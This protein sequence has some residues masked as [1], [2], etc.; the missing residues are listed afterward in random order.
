MWHKE[1]YIIFDA[2]NVVVVHSINVFHLFTNIKNIIDILFIIIVI[3]ILLMKK[4]H[5]KVPTETIV[6][7]GGGKYIGETLN[8]TRHGRGTLIWANGD[9]YEGVWENNMRHV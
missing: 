1:I 5:T 6:Y 7:P 8:G 3:E 9:K 2:H 4:E